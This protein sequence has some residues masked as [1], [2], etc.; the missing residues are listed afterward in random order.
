M[1]WTELPSTPEDEALFV[2]DCLYATLAGHNHW[3][4]MAKCMGITP[5]DPNYNE[6]LAKIC[7]GSRTREFELMVADA[8]RDMIASVQDR[9]KSNL[10]LYVNEAESIAIKGKDERNKVAMLKDLLDRAGTGAAHKV[11]IS[12]ASEYKKMVDN[13]LKE[14]E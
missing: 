3:T 1:Q 2:R 13:W 12:T 8:R 11:A 9:L 5:E 7:K 6:L 10:H 4:S 14:P